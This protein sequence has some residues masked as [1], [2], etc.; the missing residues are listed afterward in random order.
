MPLSF[1]HSQNPSS[2]SFLINDDIEFLSFQI[3]YLVLVG[4]LVPCNAPQNLDQ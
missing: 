2:L 4:V 1:W 3:L